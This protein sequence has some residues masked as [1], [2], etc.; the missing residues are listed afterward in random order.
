MRI[1]ERPSSNLRGHRTA[2][3]V[4]AGILCFCVLST[5]GCF[6]KKRPAPHLGPVAFA[7]PVIPAAME[8][9]QLEEPP[10][11]EVEATAAPK[12]TVATRSGPTRP[13]VI[14]AQPA[15]PPPAE[16]A[17]DAVIEP[18]LTTE[19]MSAAQA[20][21]QHSLDVAEWN[22]AQAQKKRLNETQLDVVSKVRGFMESS[23]EAGKNGDWQ[24]AKNLATKAE[25]LS[26]ELVKE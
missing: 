8:P 20:E 25:V 19:Q 17:P 3:K 13:R 24:R 23:K 1:D 5:S 10:D 11:L 12:L 18:E 14:Q 9:A 16:V 6:D 7:H 4:V 15:E 26:S 22:L 21:T 2:P